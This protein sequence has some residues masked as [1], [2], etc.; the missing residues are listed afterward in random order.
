MLS[1]ASLLISINTSFGTS[2]TTGLDEAV[3]ILRSIKD[4]T[5]IARAF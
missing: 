5:T 1:S 4:N 2:T 3:G